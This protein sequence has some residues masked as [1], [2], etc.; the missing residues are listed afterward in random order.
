VRCRNAT[1]W[2]IFADRSPFANHCPVFAKAKV[3]S[4]AAAVGFESEV[5]FSRAFKKCVGLSPH[6]WRRRGVDTSIQAPLPR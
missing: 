3:L 2:R 4:V 1:S 6:E 5:A